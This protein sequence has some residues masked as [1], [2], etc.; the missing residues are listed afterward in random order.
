MCERNINQP[1][2]AHPQPGTRSET[3]ACALTRNR[4]GYFSVRRP[5]LNP[6]KLGLAFYLFHNRMDPAEYEVMCPPFL[7]KHYTFSHGNKCILNTVF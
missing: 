6:H 4:T 7:N 2:L 1:P 5:A 3:Q